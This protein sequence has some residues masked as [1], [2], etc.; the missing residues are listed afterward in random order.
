MLAQQ[1]RTALG[2]PAWGFVACKGV[3]RCPPTPQNLTIRQDSS[4]FCLAG[5]P[6]VIP[7]QVSAA[8]LSVGFLG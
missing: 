7:C 1:K 8:V 3:R 6:P 4:V 2:G 5:S